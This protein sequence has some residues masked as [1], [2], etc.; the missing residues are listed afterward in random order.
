MYYTVYV[1]IAH[2]QWEEH[3]NYEVEHIFTIR[4]VS[5]WLINGTFNKTPIKI[6]KHKKAFKKIVSLHQKNDSTEVFDE[7]SIY[8]DLFL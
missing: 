8:I 6:V 5:L 3:D 4:F 7:W 2:I 1:Y